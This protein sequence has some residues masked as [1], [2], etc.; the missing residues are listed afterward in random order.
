MR[1]LGDDLL[2]RRAS[3]RL[4]LQAAGLVAAAMLLLVSLVT[5][6]VVRGQQN[7]T[8]T[9]LRTTAATADD[10]GDPPSGSWILISN[11][12]RLSMSAGLPTRLG[13]SLARLRRSPASHA[14]PVTLTLGD[15]HSY[16]VL[17]RQ[18]TAVTIQVILDLQP[19]EQERERLVKATA[20]SAALS[21]LIAA[22]LGVLLG[23]RAVRPLAQALALQRTFVADA[24]HELR[25]PLTL[26]STRVQVL[27]HELRTSGL[28]EQVLA[29]SRGV[30]ADVQRLGEVVEDLL[31]AADPRRDDLHEP[32]DLGE[33]VEAVIASAYAHALAAGVRL[34]AEPGPE[35]APLRVRGSVSALRRAVLALV[36][37]AIDHTPVGGRVQLTIRRHRRTVVLAVNDSGP[38]VPPE[39]AERVLRRFH[40]GGQ[41]SGRAHYGLGLALTH[42]VAN[43]HG[44]QLR[45][46]PSETGATFELVLPAVEG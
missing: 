24:S 29:D 28:G 15:G 4:A 26:L 46:V 41:R 21:L 3:R 12:G 31:I 33:L 23:R 30:V 40:S 16:R 7:A 8:A 39:A 44:G 35:R 34:V 19:Q 18:R 10:V 6:V 37:N 14:D 45:L 5:L 9:L 42:D 36:D 1:L 38:G 32:L 13:G 2:V 22:G 43:R 11:A 17:T 20:V 27:N 25:T